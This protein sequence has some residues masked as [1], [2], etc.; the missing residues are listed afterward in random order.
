MD[1]ACYN[2]GNGWY[3]K[4]D[5]SWVCQNCGH[6]IDDEEEDEEKNKKEF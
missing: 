5:K 1:T 4:M 2:C 6:T 3:L